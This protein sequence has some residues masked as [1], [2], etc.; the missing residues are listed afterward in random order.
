MEK[1][2]LKTNSNL[3]LADLL[4]KIKNDSNVKP[5]LNDLKVTDEEIITYYE[6]F[7]YYVTINQKCFHC[8]NKNEC[9]HSTKGMIYQIVRDQYQELTDNFTICKFYQDYYTRKNNLL[10]TTFNVEELLDE[11]QKNF[12]L[13]NVA[14]LGKEFT[15]KIISLLKGQRISGAF[16]QLK[17]SKIRL[18][19]LKSLAFGLLLK[20]QVCI[21]KFSDL[22]KEIKNDFKYT[23]KEDTFSLVLKSDILIIDGLGNESITTWSRDEVL[24]SLLDNRL[25][26]DKTTIL[27][28]EFSL[29]EL[30]KSYKI[31]YNDEAKAQHLIDKILEI[32]K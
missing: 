18:K 17:D 3:N 1:L 26:S 4:A 14:L 29:D 16:L 2:N 19:L 10:F 5:L 23:D 27:C 25:Q 31:S 22:L 6:L 11:S 12:I 15:T 20:Y 7:N 21:V 32:K 13:D 24:L 28:S 30:A 8:Q 9:N